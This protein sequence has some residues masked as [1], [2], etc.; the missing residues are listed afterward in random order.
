MNAK[1][2]ANEKTHTEA[3]IS[4][5][6]SMGKREFVNGELGKTES[7][8]PYRQANCSLVVQLQG[9]R[10][11]PGKVLLADLHNIT[12]AL[13]TSLERFVMSRVEGVR[14]LRP[15]ERGKPAREYLRLY[16]SDVRRGSTLMEF[17]LAED[18]C[19]LEA[20]KPG[21]DLLV[22]FVEGLGSI[23]DS[24][25]EVPDGFDRGVLSG[26]NLMKPA[27]S[28]GIDE[29]KFTVRGATKSVKSSFSS[30]T[31][32]RIDSLLLRPARNRRT[33]SGIILGADFS[34]PEVRFELYTKEGDA[35]PCISSED[36]LS[37][38]LDG[39][40]QYAR[41]TGDAEED[42]ETGKISRLRAD[43]IEFISGT[44]PFK[45]PYGSIKE[46]WT[47]VDLEALIE[48]QGIMPFDPEQAPDWQVPSDDEIERYFKAIRRDDQKAR[49]GRVEN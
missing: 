13:N 3:E 20:K 11:Q 31:S 43:N 1:K 34:S 19:L 7:G 37:V 49:K 30:A 25:K 15:G 10:V 21:T 22:E 29:I 12:N 26:I 27:F 48:R 8:S 35:I 18:Q 39:L 36:D 17:Q 47:G 4:M 28:R 2:G 14:S 9:P 44:E 42:P 40:M 23:Q 38:V 32:M 5:Q 45:L 41:I 33:L 6:G 24:R 46:F 16:L